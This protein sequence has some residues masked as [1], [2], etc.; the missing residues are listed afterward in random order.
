MRAKEFITETENLRRSAEAAIPDAHLY[1]ALDNSS[2]YSSY[3]YG[4]ALA[5]SPDNHMDQNGP[6]QSKMVTLAYTDG[7]AEII[8]KANKIMGVKSKAL[9]SKKSHES[10][11]VDNN[12]SPVATPKRNKYGV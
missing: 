1:P 9:S 11:T 7:D 10:S 3:R 4:I 5:V 8:N 6:T 2:P 12:N